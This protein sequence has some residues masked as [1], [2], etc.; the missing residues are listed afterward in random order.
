[1]HPRCVC[2]CVWPKA[3]FDCGTGTIIITG[4]VLL[5]IHGW[6]DGRMDRW[7]D[8]CMHG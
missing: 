8:G 5:Q 7:V 1:M 3:L 4:T 2:M 6:M